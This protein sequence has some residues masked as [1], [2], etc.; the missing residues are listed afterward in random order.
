MVIKFG[1]FSIKVY[2]NGKVYFGLFWHKLSWYLFPFFL[3]FTKWQIAKNLEIT[4][5][6]IFLYVFHW[7]LR[8][9][10]QSLENF[11][12][13]AHGRWHKILGRE[14]TFCKKFVTSFSHQC[15]VTHAKFHIAT[16]KGALTL[17]RVNVLRRVRVLHET[18]DGGGCHIKSMNFIEI[19]DAD[20]DEGRGRE[21]GPV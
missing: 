17:I 18:A 14:V 13:G 5:L 21:R 12:Q 3:D 11:V 6:T 2:I 8:Y 10:K 4:Y 16:S 1:Q 19:A 20:A 9:S 7:V 15:R